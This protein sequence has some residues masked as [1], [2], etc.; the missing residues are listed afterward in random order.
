M[1]KVI[2]VDDEKQI[3]DGLSKMI[4]WPE[5]GYEVVATARNGMEAIP[6]IKSIK[7]D[8][9]VTDV[10][11]PEM[12][13]LKMLELVRRH[14]S[15]DVEF[16]ILSGFSDFQYARK[17]MQ[18]NVRSYILK[19]IDE[20]ELYGALLDIKAVLNDKEIRANHRIRSFLNGFLF[21][22]EA[23][24]PE[25]FP[26]EEE[27]YGL[28]YVVVQRHE[29]Y[30]SLSASGPDDWRPDLFQAVAGLFGDASMRFVLRQ[31]R[32]RCHI[33]VGKSLLLR[34]DNDPRRLVHSLHEHLSAAAGIQT[35]ILVGRH[36]SGS[37]DLH[38][39]VQS[40]Y[41]CRNKMFYMQGPSVIFHE[42]ICNEKFSKAYEDNG[43]VIK[44]ISAFRKNDMD[45]LSACIVQMV[46]HF[47]KLQVVPE[48]AL[49]HLDSTM[50]SVLQILSESQEDVRSAL[51]QYAFFKRIQSRVSIHNLADLALQFCQ[52][53]NSLS[54]AGKRIEH[55][56]IVARVARY[57]E[58]N[59]A[60]PLK[61][62]D[63]ADRFYVNPAYLGQQF[64]KKRGFSLNHYINSVRIEKAK[65]L[66]ATT[67]RRVYE[68]AAMAGFDDPNYFSSKFLEYTGCT[69]SEY[70]GQ[71]EGSAARQS[72]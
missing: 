7:P 19:P 13:G 70:R 56:D 10:R 31:D 26:D 59:Y 52:A 20:S 50:A 21:C 41:H 32:D 58:E 53:C 14:I 54:L 6:L 51:E 22:G 28:R 9:V 45:R 64:A 12:D 34:Y 57:V 35:D 67:P 42:D 1:Y 43:L 65:E 37:R 16:I 36:V 4:R 66:L 49:V 62:N 60:Q 48:I 63:I 30:E 38:E 2:L 61:I 5:L 3:T 46:E 17:A 33:V 55:G 24:T 40:I 47:T 27:Q 44:T 68:I 8:L 71:S 39:S 29:L 18:F 15:Q 11:M 72:H 25:A 69:P 23:E